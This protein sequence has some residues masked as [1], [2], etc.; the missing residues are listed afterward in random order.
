MILSTRLV[1]CIGVFI[2]VGQGLL[3]SNLSLSLSLSVDSPFFFFFSVLRPA[4]ALLVVRPA[5]G[6]VMY[7]RGK[8]YALIASPRSQAVV[9]QNKHNTSH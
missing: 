9:R 8:R 2:S 6:P 5:W 1:S 3:T 4:T 7:S